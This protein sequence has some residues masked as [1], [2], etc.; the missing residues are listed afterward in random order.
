VCDI[1][2]TE[3]R[4]ST[5][6]DVVHRLTRHDTTRHAGCTGDE[7]FLSHT[8]RILQWVNKERFWLL[9]NSTSCLLLLFLLCCLL[10]KTRLISFREQAESEGGVGCVGALPLGGRWELCA[11]GVCEGSECVISKGVMVLL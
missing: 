1:L 9:G 3:A 6:G 2:Y 11:S 10:F 4:G 7:A 5:V 8:L